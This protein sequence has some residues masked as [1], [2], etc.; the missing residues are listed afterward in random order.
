ML[1]KLPL[2]KIRIIIAK[3]LYR[4]VHIFKK[5]KQD[6]TR[7]GINYS[8]DLKEGIDF[9]IFLLGNFQKYI[10]DSPLIKFPSNYTVI[11]VGANIGQMTLRFA[12]KENC[13]TVFAFEPTDFA[14]AKLKKNVGLN[15]QLSKK[16]TPIKS[17]VSDASETISELTAYA[18]WKLA[19]SKN[20]VVHPLHLGSITGAEKTP[21]TT[22]DDFIK[23]NE[24]ENL[25]LIKIDTDG[26]EPKVL[27]GAMKT[28]KKYKPYIIFEA[29]LY[30][31]E[32]AGGSFKDY[33]ELFSTLNFTFYDL[34]SEKKVTPEN[35]KA[36]I[37]QNS[38]TD[39]LAIF[40]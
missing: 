36:L 12:Q 16:I 27:K 13:E 30:I 6:V 28:I 29:G 10:S 24:I 25:A 23:Q 22:I 9:S 14:F 33:F 11:D 37:P 2:T 38:T 1:S 20:E 35:Y 3:I 34:K 7:G 8:L 26:N 18:S 39:I 15:P 32:E 31:I 21:S 4:I 19:G 5:D 17:F 40:R